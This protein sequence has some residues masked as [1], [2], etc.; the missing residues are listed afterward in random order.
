MDCRAQNTK[1]KYKHGVVLMCTQVKCIKTGNERAFA[2]HAS[3]AVVD[4][5]G[6]AQV[7]SD[8]IEVVNLTRVGE[9]N[10]HEK[11]TGSLFEVDRHH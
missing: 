4:N 8:L 2:E 7:L 11:S 6:V 3:Y 10:F 1:P 9:F 5:H